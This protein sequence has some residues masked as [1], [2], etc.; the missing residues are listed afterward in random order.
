MSEAPAARQVLAIL[1]LLARRGE[2]L[3][4]ASIATQ[5]GLARSTTYRL[6][7]TLV[8]AGYVVHLAEE[9]RYGLGMA[10]HELG[11]AYTRQAPLQRLARPLLAALVQATGHNGHF[12]AL[13]GADVLYLL[14]ERH[15]GRPSLVTDVGV[16][17]PAHLTA[18]GRALLA[19]LSTRQI[20]ALYPSAAALVQRDGRGFTKVSQLRS[21]LA[22]VRQR[23]F[24]LEEG[25]VSPELSSV[26][27]AAVDH[28]GH[29]AAS[30]AVTYRHEEVDAS[31]RERLVTAVR[32]AAAVLTTRLAGSH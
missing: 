15:P 21:E 12:V 28:V 29:P 3:A 32:R 4:A 23:G 14:E 6:L 17:L 11:S 25:E 19:G 7:D 2:P 22:A 30:F 13:H 31:E 18:S 9:R 26:A 20:S 5:I 1:T 27:V 10:A 16:R 8:E 24:A